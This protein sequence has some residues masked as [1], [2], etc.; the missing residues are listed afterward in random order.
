[1]LT[2]DRRVLL[3]QPNRF[4]VRS[5]IV[6]EKHAWLVHFDRGGSQITPPFDIHEHPATLIRLVAGLSSTDEAMLGL[7]D[8]IQWT[9]VDGRKAEGTLTTTGPS[10]E[11]KTY[12]IV[13]QIPTNRDS[14]R[15]RATTCWRVRD[16]ETL[17]EF[18]VKDSW[19]PDDRSPEYE[20][21][22]LTK[23]IP[24]VAQVVS[25]ETRKVEVKELRCPSTVG[26]FLNRVFSRMTSRLYGK[27]LTSFASTLQLLCAMRDAL[28]GTYAIPAHFPHSDPVQS[29][30]KTGRRRCADSSPRHIH[31][32]RPSWPTRRD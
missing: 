20:L 28:A 8:S 6:T 31:Q 13:D 12:P 19:R 27:P 10:G 30:P 29:P 24:G 11:P 14:I 15:G 18:V 32:Q 3:S 5:L 23:D 2:V 4:F 1:M 16:P 21:F 25:H 17:E 26:Q 7:D 9:I 22:E